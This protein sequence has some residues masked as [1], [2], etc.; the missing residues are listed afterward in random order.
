M[1]A[2]GSSGSVAPA[3]PPFLVVVFLIY[4]PTVGADAHFDVQVDY[5]VFRK[6]PQGKDSAAAPP[7]APAAASATPRA[8][9][10]PRCSL[11]DPS[12]AIVATAPMTM[13]TATGH[14]ERP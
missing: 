5:H 3:K 10:A 7:G 6:D 4:N 13:K 12:H 9:S 8:T 1:T 14:S 11:C 2:R